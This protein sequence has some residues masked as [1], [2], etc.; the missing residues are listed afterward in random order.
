MNAPDVALHEQRRFLMVAFHPYG[1]DVCE[2][3]GLPTPSLDVGSVERQAALTPWADL[4]G[5]T[6]NVHNRTVSTPQ[7]I[8]LAQLYERAAASLISV[9]HP[10]YHRSLD[11]DLISFF[12][13]LVSLGGFS[14]HS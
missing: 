2:L 1:S 8:G 11:E 12:I 6:G 5:G 7:I 9:E 10:N 4:F 14:E 3:L 13:A